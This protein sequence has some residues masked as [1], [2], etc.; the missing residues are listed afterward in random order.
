M[1]FVLSEINHEGVVMASDSSQTILDNA[2][3]KITGF[4]EKEKT[5]YFKGLNIGLSSWGLAQVGAQDIGI[6]LEGPVKEFMETVNQTGNSD[7]LAAFT[8]FLARQLDEAF[9][10]DG[11][12]ENDSLHMGLHIC[13]YNS[14]TDK[15]P[16]M[17]HIYINPG[18]NRFIP[19]L[20][21]IPSLPKGIPANHL[22]NG[23]HEE[24]W[25]KPN[26]RH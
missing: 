22:R 16:G 15:S 12:K 4:V 1:T 23:I 25:I 8:N 9:K 14:S 21:V 26:R 2:T 7:R 20:T 19:E 11:K 6:W 24:F 10:L 17:C 3:K 18:Q 5:F 13:G